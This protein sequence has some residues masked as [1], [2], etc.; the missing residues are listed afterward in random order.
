MIN[1][2]KGVTT[3]EYIVT[4]EWK[5]QVECNFILKIAEELGMVSLSTQ[6][7]EIEK[8]TVWG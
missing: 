2:I 6:E 3:N 8:I 1:K 5:E 4:D 7:T